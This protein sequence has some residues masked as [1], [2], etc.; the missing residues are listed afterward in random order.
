MISCIRTIHFCYGHR[1][2][3]HEHKCATLHGHNGLA[4]IHAT[5]MAGLDTVGRVIDFSVL[6]ERIG[7]W[8]EENWDHTMILCSDDHETLELM[9]R[10]PKCKDVF[11]LDVNPT[12]ENLAKHLFWHVCPEL[13]RETGI[14][15]NKVVFW[16]TPNCRAEESLP[17]ED[18]KLSALYNVYGR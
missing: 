1:I 12:A 8:I 6:K 7:G 11:V 14:I 3:G 10:A 16:E 4:E 2:M 17:L 13:L 15:V 9:N 18:E 5:P